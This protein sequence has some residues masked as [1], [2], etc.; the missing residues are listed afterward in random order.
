MLL[1]VAGLGH[2]VGE[3]VLFYG[4]GEEVG[5]IEGGKTGGDGGDDVF[6]VFHGND[7]VLDVV[8]GLGEDGDGVDC[9]SS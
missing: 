4:V 1:V 7:G 2:H 3:A 9:R 8:G 5:F 6:S